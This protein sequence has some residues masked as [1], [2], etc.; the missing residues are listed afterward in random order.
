MQANPPLAQCYQCSIAP[1][2]HIQSALGA[3]RSS[4]LQNACP[5]IKSAFGPM[6]EYTI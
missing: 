2:D 4:A 5:N 3:M 1:H 6:R